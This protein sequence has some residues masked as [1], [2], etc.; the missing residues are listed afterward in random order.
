M[1]QSQL[2]D[3]FTKKILSKINTSGQ[4]LIVCRK[5]PA[6]HEGECD[7]TKYTMFLDQLWWKNRIE[8]QVYSNVK[9]RLNQC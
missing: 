2:T 5:Y 4:S 7:F 6:S 3:K 9:F 1:S 8:G